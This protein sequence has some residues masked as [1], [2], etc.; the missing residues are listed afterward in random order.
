MPRL[1]HQY[2]SQ[3]THAE[4]DMPMRETMHLLINAQQK[5]ARWQKRLTLVIGVLMVLQVATLI[6]FSFNIV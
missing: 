3:Q 6:A 1:V 4:Q 2:L 5:Q